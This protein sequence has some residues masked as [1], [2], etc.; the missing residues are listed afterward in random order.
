MDTFDYVQHFFHRLA[1]AHDANRLLQVELHPGLNCDLYRCPHCY[2]HGQRPLF[3]EALSPHEIGIAL[4]DIVAFGPTIIV[5]GVTTEPLTHPQAASVLAEVRRRRLPLGLYTK[6]RRLEGDVVDALLDGSGECF[7]TVSVDDVGR[8]GYLS[9]HGIAVDSREGGALGLRGV[10]YQQRVLSNLRAFKDRRDA[11]GAAVELRVA[12][13]LFADNSNERSVVDAV[14]TLVDL[15][16]R[17]RIAFPQDRND[18]H[19][20]G[21]M[22]PDTAEVLDRVRQRFA[23]NPKVRI[24]LNTATAR[25]DSCF[26]QCRAQ[27][28]QVTIDKSGNIFPCPQVAVYP[29]RHLSYGNIR[30]QPLSVLLRSSKR[31]AMFDLDVDRDMRCRICDRKDEAINVALGGLSDAFDGRATGH[32]LPT[33]HDG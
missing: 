3:G 14:R 20:A 15:A 21:E 17:V 4:D 1:S 25:R 22:P 5:S 9:R 32:D 23:D 7:V 26:T 27:R 12:L 33:A 13:L 6:G 10:D 28:F 30:D 19:P 16:D 18:G 2:G 24:L 31:R 29:F 11:L 8:A